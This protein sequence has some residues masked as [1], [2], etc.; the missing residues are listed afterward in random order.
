M[1]TSTRRNNLLGLL[2]RFGITLFAFWWVLRSVDPHVLRQVFRSASIPWLWM[3][4]AFF[5]VAQVGCIVRW[6]L[7]APR[8]PS[9]KWPFLANSFF[10]ANFFNMFLPTTIG[11]DV[12]RGYD[13]IKAT[14]EWKGSLASILADRLTG[15]VG[16]F[17]FALA[18]WVAFPPARQDP[19]VRTAFAGFCGL[20]VVT[21][22][23]LGS[24][25]ILQRMLM[26][27][28]KIGVGQ[29]QSHAK[30]FQDALRASL[31]RPRL[32]LAVLGVTA[33]IQLC[34]IL[35]FWAIARA[36]HIAVA[37]VYLAL[38]VPI[39][40]TLAQ[41]PISLNGWG[42]REGATVLFLG[43]IGV[44]T[45]HALSLSLFCA[46]IPLLSAVLGGFLFLLRR[47][48]KPVKTDA[49]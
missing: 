15:F 27:F 28:G 16:F 23:V 43:R 33:L 36:L 48:R 8:H 11:G 3:G 9:L 5:S 6:G 26:P 29:L 49:S 40:L 22:L 47:R 31:S 21:F 39:I 1:T 35:M 17:T 44:T 25:R 32:L 46:M 34:T 42:I 19:L 14:G 20:V 18:A 30:Q 41:I 12:I 2:L 45:E 38:T 37:L 4:I 10:V 7:L 13:L 24:R